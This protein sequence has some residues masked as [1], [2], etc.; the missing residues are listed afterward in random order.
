MATYIGFS[1][2]NSTATPYSIT[3][4]FLVEKD[5]NPVTISTNR[6]FKKTD[7]DLV[8]L[9]F[10]NALNIPQGQKPGNP[11]YGT[12]LWGYI[13]DQNDSQLIQMVDEEIRR[14]GSLDR[15]LILNSVTVLSVENGMMISVELAITPFN[16]PSTI[17]VFFDQTTN[18]ASMVS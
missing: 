18:T 4:G 10:I 16:E 2:V 8:I 5:E 6:K 14:V 11:A 12:S 13:F 17:N 7:Q 9:D 1:T 15:R 3:D